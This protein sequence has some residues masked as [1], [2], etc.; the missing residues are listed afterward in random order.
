[1]LCAGGPLPSRALCVLWHGSVSASA[2]AHDREVAARL[3][4]RPSEYECAR[5]WPQEGARGRRDQA[6]G[7]SSSSEA[8]RQSRSRRSAAQSGTSARRSARTA[9]QGRCRVPSL[10]SSHAPRPPREDRTSPDCPERIVRAGQRS[11]CRPPPHSA[12]GPP[13]GRAATSIRHGCKQRVPAATRPMGRSSART[14]RRRGHRSAARGLP[15]SRTTTPQCA[16]SGKAQG[17]ERRCQPSRLPARPP[18]RNTRSRQVD[19]S[20]GPFR[21]QFPAPTTP[22]QRQ[23]S[24]R[25]P[26]TGCPDRSVVL[27]RTTPGPR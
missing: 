22:R 10:R 21:S 5:R 9:R 19:A 6:D 15:R 18:L 27:G 20:P 1:M 16:R 13:R 14:K 23:S 24:R 11:P 7:T 4:G 8:D 3:L 12:D 17:A 26:R 25:S 2:D